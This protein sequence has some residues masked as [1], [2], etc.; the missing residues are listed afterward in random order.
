MRPLVSVLITSYNREK[1]LAEAI[2]SVLASS[3]HNFELI[4]VDDCSTDNTIN[5][6]RDYE[7]K[8]NRI[9]VYINEKNVGQFKNRNIAASYATGVFIKYLD[10]DDVM[11]PHCLDVM[12]EAMEKYPEAGA[13]TVTIE[14]P[15]RRGLPLEYSPRE[16]YLN[17]FF[18]GNSILYVGPS[19][20]I[21]KKNVFNEFNGF[22]E[23]IGILADTLLMFK[24][25]AKYSI[26]AFRDGLFDWRVHDEQVT[27]EQKNWFEMQRQRNQINELVLDSSDLP[28]SKPETKIIKRNMRNI[29]IRSMTKRLIKK[30]NFSE[31]FQLSGI[32][33]LRLTDYLQAMLPNKK[34]I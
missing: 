20:C 24:I 11:F 8:D 32:F 1:Y 34:L 21:F 2:E 18:A 5:I 16:S 33:S 19:G 22:D 3:Y 6:I 15:D 13:G 28:L 10:S 9:K 7:V 30:R 14:R 4:I 29:M 25:A 26:V 23:Q 31:F 27:I 17:H 12:V